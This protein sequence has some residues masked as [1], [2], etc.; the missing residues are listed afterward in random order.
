MLFKVLSRRSHESTVHARRRRAAGPALQPVGAATNLCVN[1]DRRREAVALHAKALRPRQSVAL[2]LNPPGGT[3]SVAS[4]FR[5]LR[6]AWRCARRKT[7][8]DRAWPSIGRPR[9][10]VALHAKALR[11]RQSVALHLNP[12]G[13]TR[14]VASVFRP[15]RFAWRCARRKTGHDRAWPSIGRPR[16]TVALHAKALRP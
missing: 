11:P 8:H 1:E 14:S 2:H 3:R 9:E 4:V 12:P 16:E 15:L 13:G 7:G 10:A 6:F 5:P